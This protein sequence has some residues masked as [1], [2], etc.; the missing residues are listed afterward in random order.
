MVLIV[1]LLVLNFAAILCIVEVPKLLRSG[2]L[3]E[4]LTFSLLLALGVSLSILKSL[5]VEI[6]NPS[7][8][9]AWIYSPL[10]GVMESL[11]KKG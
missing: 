7:D 8:L 5:K 9:F 11:L 2:L 4:L 3:K 1:I 6:G 10:K